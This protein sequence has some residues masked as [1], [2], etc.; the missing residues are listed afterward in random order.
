MELLIL[1]HGYNGWMVG[2]DKK[3]KTVVIIVLCYHTIIL[4][5]QKSFIIYFCVSA[6]KSWK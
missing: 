1:G 2:F 3:E 4:L 5:Q 6:T